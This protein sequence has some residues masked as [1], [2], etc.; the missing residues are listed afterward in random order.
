MNEYY[1]TCPFPKPQDTKKKKLMNG[2]KDKANRICAYCGRP[3]AERHEI[4]GGP[5]RQISI[6]Y[7]FQ[8]DVC[9]DHH[10]LL[11]ENIALW[12]QEQN[13]LLRAKCEREYLDNLI[14]D[15]LTEEQ[16][17]DMWMQLIGKNYIDELIPQ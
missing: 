1:R 6:R 16:A 9:N 3:N 11:Q 2:Y 7:G 15:G 12:A 17:L 13:R 4:F 14:D 8:I 5:N 10:G